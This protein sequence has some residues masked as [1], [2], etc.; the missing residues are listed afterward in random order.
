MRPERLKKARLQREN[1]EITAEELRKIED[2]EI[3]KLVEEQK[4][5]GLKFVTD[6]EFRR[7]WWHFDFLSGFDGVEFIETEKGS[8]SKV[9]NGER[10]ALK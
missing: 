5:A 9:F 7:K 2:E 10:M 6:G 1:G 4:T 3:T 8:N